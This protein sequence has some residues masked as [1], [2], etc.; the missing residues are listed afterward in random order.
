MAAIQRIPIYFATASEGELERKLARSKPTHAVNGGALV[1][2]D[3]TSTHTAAGLLRTTRQWQPHNPHHAASSCQHFVGPNNSIFPHP[4][5]LSKTVS[6]WASR[7]CRWQVKAETY[8]GTV[9]DTPL[10]IIPRSSQ[11]VLILNTGDGQSTCLRLKQLP[12]ASL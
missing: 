11:T 4:S 3:G 12:L 10:Q 6:T 7:Q 9:R 2:R 5:P 8:G 1:L